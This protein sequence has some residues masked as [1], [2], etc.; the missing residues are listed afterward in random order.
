MSQAQDAL[1]AALAT[2]D[3][4]LISK[5]EGVIEQY[6][7]DSGQLEDRVSSA[8]ESVGLNKD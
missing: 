1:P 4:E 6:Y 3:N 8:W 5:L 7:E 2:Q